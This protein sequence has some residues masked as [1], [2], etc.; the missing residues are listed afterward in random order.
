MLD[1][2]MDMCER[3]IEYGDEMLD[4]WIGRCLPAAYFVD[5]SFFIE[6]SRLDMERCGSVGKPPLPG[7]P[8]I[9][10]LCPEIEDRVTGFRAVVKMK[11]AP[12]LE[13]EVP[14]RRAT[15]TVSDPLKPSRRKYN[16]PL[17][18]DQ[19]RQTRSRILD[20]AYR[21]FVDR[22][23]AGTTIAAVAETAKVSPETV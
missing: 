18:A 13:A 10:A 12:G 4:G 16:S 8:G 22:G 20:A 9:S 14:V 1:P 19:A 7:P 21:L 23:Y 15:F 3:C 2:S 11:G 5:H 17:R 6:S